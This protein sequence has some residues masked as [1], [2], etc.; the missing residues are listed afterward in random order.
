MKDLKQKLAI[1]FKI[2]FDVRKPYFW[3]IL[4]FLFGFIVRFISIYPG[5]ILFDYDQFED[6]FHTKKIIV[7]LDF[8]VIGRAIYGDPRLHHGVVYFYYNIIPFILFKWNPILIAL[9]NSVFNA[10]IAIILFFFAKRLFNKTVPALIAAFLVSISYEFVQFSGWLSSTTITLVTVPL[11]FYGLWAYYQK[12]DW[13]LILA[14]F[15]LGISIQAEI[16]HLYL[17]PIF[18][19]YWLALKPAFPK[20]KTL[21]LSIATLF[22]SV[23]TL[24]LTEIKLKFAGVKALLNFG[25]IFDDS[26]ISYI[27]R[28]RLFLKDLWLTFSNNLLPHEPKWGYLIGVLIIV[29]TFILYFVPSFIYSSRKK[30]KSFF[31]KHFK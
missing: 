22:L 4:I 15:F 6:L 23:S 11:F 31:H 9:W 24:I 12:R 13:G 21:I 14:A 29:F 25:E 17:I 5:N 3:A 7:D 26:K 10:G 28:L 19:I 2:A 27:D 8:P 20:K 1:Y 16:P 18:F 30:I